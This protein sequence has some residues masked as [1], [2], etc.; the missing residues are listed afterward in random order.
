MNPI[1]KRRVAHNRVIGFSQ[2]WVDLDL[3]LLKTTP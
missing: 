1:L 3:D 2:L